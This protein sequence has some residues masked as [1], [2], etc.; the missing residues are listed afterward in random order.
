MSVGLS[1][2]DMS[3]AF[4]CLHHSLLLAKLEAYGLKNE[5]IK[6]MKSYFMDRF[7]RLRIGGIASSW[8][9]VKKGCPQEFKNALQKVDIQSLISS[10]NCKNCILCKS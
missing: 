5:S 10:N 6:L 9:R 2:T 8:K 1:S 3:K 4:D 7:N